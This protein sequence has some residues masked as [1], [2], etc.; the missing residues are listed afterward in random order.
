MVVW[1]F[2]LPKRLTGA[3]R[4]GAAPGLSKSIYPWPPT[5]PF[6][7]PTVKACAA[8]TTKTAATATAAIVN[9][10]DIVRFFIVRFIGGLDVPSCLEPDPNR[11]IW[12]Q[13]GS[14]L[15]YLKTELFHQ[16]APLLF[17]PGYISG[18]G[19]GR[20]GQRFRAF[21]GKPGLHILGRKRG[22]QFLVEPRDDRRRGSG[23]RRQPVTQRDLE[24]RHAAFGDRRKLRQQARSPG[25]GNG[26][27]AQGSCLDVAE[28]NGDRQEHHR[29]MSAEQVAHGR[30]V[31]FVR[32]VLK[33]HARFGRE[34]FEGKVID[35]ADAG[36]SVLQGRG[37]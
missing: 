12:L 21:G 9:A 37:R 23:R 14:N 3:M 11:T 1:T 31:A 16:P 4:S 7:S 28:R 34:I 15:F 32:H 22:I 19:L 26:E 6:A 10:R 29:N 33:L 8:D 17:L 25:A 18:I 36:R 13:S 5:G 2:S 30:T 20:S 27:R 35:R 24:P